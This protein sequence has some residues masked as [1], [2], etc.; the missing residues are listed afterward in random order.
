[1]K[2]FFLLTVFVSLLTSPSLSAQS[3]Q[4]HVLTLAQ[5]D[6]QI[7]KAQNIRAQLQQLTEGNVLAEVKVDDLF[8][9][10][11]DNEKA[12]EQEKNNLKNEQ[13]NQIAQTAN[14]ECFKKDKALYQKYLIWNNIKRVITTLKLDFL[15]MP[16]QKRAA[17]LELQE[18]ALGQKTDAIEAQENKQDALERA[19]EA[20]R[21]QRLAQKSAK[22]END[23]SKKEFSNQKARL[24]E[25]R[26]KLAD[27]TLMYSANYHQEVLEQQNITKILGDGANTIGKQDIDTQALQKAYANTN[28]AWRSL[29]NRITHLA[30]TPHE[31]DQLPRIDTIA[32]SLYLELGDS[33]NAKDLRN[34]YDKTLLERDD[35][36]ALIEKNNLAIKTQIYK[37]LYL[38]GK[39]RSQL[40]EQLV[41]RE[42][43]QAFLIDNDYFQ[44][45]LLEIKLIPYRPLVIAKNLVMNFVD[46]LQK[47]VGAVM[48]IVRLLFLLLLAVLVP[49]LLFR[50]MAKGER[51]LDKLKSWILQNNPKD[52]L[53]LKLALWLQRLTP[54]FSWA[55]MLAAAQLSNLFLRHTEIEAMSEII[56]YLNYYFLYRMVRIFL[57]Q[58]TQFI[59]GHRY[60]LYFAQTLGQRIEKT[61]RFLAQY[62]LIYFY[63]L[64]LTQSLARKALLYFF[65]KKALLILCPFILALAANRWRYELGKAI[66]DIIPGPIGRFLH[67]LCLGR[68][69]YFFVLPVTFILLF[70]LLT[71][72]A[73]LETSKLDSAKKIS[74]QLFRKKIESNALESPQYDPSLP[75]INPLS[76][77]YKKI[78]CLENLEDKDLFIKTDDDILER[79]TTHILDWVH[80]IKDEH[81]LAVYGEKGIGKSTLLG[82]LKDNL[83]KESKVILTSVSEK[84]VTQEDLLNFLASILS[85]P[86]EHGAEGIIKIDESMAKTVVIIDEAQNL[87]LAKRGGLKAFHTMA[88][89]FNLRTKNIFWCFSFNRYS[90]SYLNAVTEGSQ[91]FRKV[92][93]LY[94]WKDSEI[95]SLIIQRHK[96]LQFQIEFDPIVYA[97]ETRPDPEEIKYTYDRFFEMLW[98]QSKGNPR[99]AMALWLSSVTLLSGNK[100]KVGLP[101]AI[102]ER[103][104][105]HL[106]NDELFVV[107]AIIR[108]ENLTVHEAMEVSNLSERVVRHAMRV[109]LERGFLERSI[110]RGRYR[111]TPLW[112]GA[113]IGQLI[114]KNFVYE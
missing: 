86:K 54:Y 83:S 26:K 102:P 41:K 85:F 92:Y 68:W 30:K 65:V 112:Q 109:G 67:R 69:S 46:Q 101:R 107:A 28:I 17:L 40:L 104:L 103:P 49:I 38:A 63:L 105:D 44:D 98:E 97:L 74:A 55:M 73:Y 91:Y 71:R 79:L 20:E 89:V 5:L 9:F 114:R 75:Q 84:I 72:K 27:F 32:E 106:T 18:Q 76:D 31:L 36:V 8:S 62:F 4:C 50:F 33:Q 111:V 11:F 29:V 93:P 25:I 15:E 23:V 81:T 100:V 1:M 45:L 94:R 43:T 16:A 3:S 113:L 47:G 6:E 42:K 90:W 48:D 12:L 57:V 61:G 99:T 66:S 14:D 110:S 24:E 51:S 39:V 60:S 88:S 59:V 35:L 96:K 108:H 82:T 52:G 80:N 77:E 2:T 21:S 95:K 13:K 70:T 7:Q 37:L 56:P 10:D 64:E 53:S 22:L 19:I 58:T 78:F 34:L 87:F